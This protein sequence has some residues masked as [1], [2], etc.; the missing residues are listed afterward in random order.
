MDADLAQAARTLW[1]FHCVHDEPAAADVIIGLGSYDDRVA[2]RCADL[3]HA[4][5]APKIIFT[6]ASGNWTKAL[7]PDGEARA[8]ARIAQHRGVPL[9]AIAVEP[10]ATHIGENIRFSA[11]MVPHARSAI[12]V[13]KPQ[14]QMRCQAT[15]RRQWPAV[16]A[17][18]TAPMTAYGH[19]P[20]P[21]HDERALICE[22][23]GDLERMRSYPDRGF[24][25]AVDIPPEVM[26]AFRRLVDAGFVDHL[27]GTT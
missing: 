1:A 14:T 11:A 3:F 16:D 21:H 12:L 9:K 15:V 13:T 8:F 20:L 23:V 24:Q 4:G 19:Q 7:F 18:V 25:M 26:G 6:G 27:Q 22:M 10:R 17:T 5:L 2:V